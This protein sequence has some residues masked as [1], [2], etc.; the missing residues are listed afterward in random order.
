MAMNFFEKFEKCYIFKF[1][2]SWFVT[3]WDF[4]TQNHYLNHP[5]VGFFGLNYFFKPIKIIIFIL[6]YKLIFR[7]FHIFKKNQ[8]FYWIKK[9]SLINVDTLAKSF[10]KGCKGC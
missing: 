8:I 4:N 1:E 2:L 7:I 5:Q 10:V 6:W 9:K 3:F